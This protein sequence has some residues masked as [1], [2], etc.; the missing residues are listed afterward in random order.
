MRLGLC[1]S[2][3]TAVNIVTHIDKPKPNQQTMD[4]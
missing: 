3:T 4:R 2:N 1:R